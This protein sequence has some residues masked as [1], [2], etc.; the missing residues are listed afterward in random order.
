MNTQSQSVSQDV[1]FANLFASLDAEEAEIGTAYL[2]AC[3]QGANRS[4]NA[5]DV[6]PH[7][8]LKAEYQGLTVA[9]LFGVYL[10]GRQNVS[11]AQELVMQRSLRLT[12]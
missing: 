6:F 11:A 8:Q 12:N 9:A 2:T 5:R 7:S 3:A 1:V 4:L 10:R